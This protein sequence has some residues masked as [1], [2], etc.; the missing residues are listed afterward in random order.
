LRKALLDRIEADPSALQIGGVT[1]KVVTETHPDRR[2][3]VKAGAKA[4]SILEKS[5]IKRQ[6][7]KPPEWAPFKWYAKAKMDGTALERPLLLV[8][9]SEGTGYHLQ[10]GTLTEVLPAVNPATVMAALKA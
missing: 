10:E 8:S 2:P 3:M 4:M 6:H 9:W 5:G 1:P 7:M